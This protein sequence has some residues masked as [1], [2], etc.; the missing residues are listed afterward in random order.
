MPSNMKGQKSGVLHTLESAF[1][2]LFQKPA[3]PEL[4]AEKFSVETA[5]TEN[6]K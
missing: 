1:R 5:S 2:L 6:K 3:L 4:E